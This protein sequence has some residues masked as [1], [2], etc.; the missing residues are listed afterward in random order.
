LIA[1]DSDKK[2]K[3]KEV[4]TDGVWEKMRDQESDSKEDG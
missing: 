4:M 3:H 1:K 2:Y